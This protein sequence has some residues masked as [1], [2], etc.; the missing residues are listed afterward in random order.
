MV[1]S[2]G[3]IACVDKWRLFKLKELTSIPS[4]S[5]TMSVMSSSVRSRSN[6]NS[7]SVSKL[8]KAACSVA[9][10]TPFSFVL[11]LST[12]LKRPSGMRA[13]GLLTIK[14]PAERVSKLSGSSLK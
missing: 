14:S 12:F 11:T 1:V 10:A 9:M 7:P 4:T 8:V 3:L 13:Y 5:G 6:T 2:N